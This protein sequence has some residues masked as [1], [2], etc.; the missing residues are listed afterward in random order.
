MQSNKKLILFKVLIDF[1]WDGYQIVRRKDIIKIR[2]GQ[3]ER[4]LQKI[5]EKQNFMKSSQKLRININ[6][7]KEVFL[8]LQKSRFKVVVVEGEEKSVDEFLIGKIE[9]V[10]NEVVDIRGISPLATWDKR[11]TIVPYKDIT[12]VAFGDEYSTV[13]VKYSDRKTNS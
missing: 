3:Y 8:S 7:S 9:K 13:L 11:P 10:D 1:H 2:S 12:R 6:N 4:C 5:L